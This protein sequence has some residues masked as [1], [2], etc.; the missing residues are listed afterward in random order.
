MSTRIASVTT[1]VVDCDD[2][3]CMQQYMA[4]PAASYEAALREAQ[5]LGWRI[6]VNTDLC[7]THA[8]KGTTG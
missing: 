6:D 5:D 4:R 7:P 1:I 3:G 8:P 2:D